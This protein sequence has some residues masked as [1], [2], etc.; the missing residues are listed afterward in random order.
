[1]ASNPV[2]RA[3]GHMSE[4]TPTAAE[5]ELMRHALGWPKDYR[6]YFSA[7]I[8][9]A[10]YHAWLEIEMRGWAKSRP[11]PVSEDR[12][13]HVTESGRAAIGLTPRA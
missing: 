4:P 10:D 8:G 7:D 9:S 3:E 1:M 5:I 2:A 13:F 6:N 11:S 12:L